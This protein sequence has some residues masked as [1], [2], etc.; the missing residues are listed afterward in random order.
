MSQR[1]NRPVRQRARAGR[2]EASRS[3]FVRE[4]HDVHHGGQT[5][6][7]ALA[8]EAAPRRRWWRRR[9]RPRA[10]GSGPAVAS[11]GPPSPGG[12]DP[13]W[14]AAAP[15]APRADASPRGRTDERSAGSYRRAHPQLL[16]DQSMGP[17][18]F[19]AD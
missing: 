17:E 8:E 14:S 7:R 18:F 16:A 12:D 5:I 2:F 6:C 19:L 15:A 1:G 13:D 10:A 11:G 3:E 9:S 4:L